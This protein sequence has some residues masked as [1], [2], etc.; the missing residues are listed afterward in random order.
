MLNLSRSHVASLGI[1]AWLLASALT[2]AQES[3]WQQR[4]NERLPPLGHRNWV[5]VADSAYP[6]QSREGIETI[7]TGEDQT[8]VLQYVFAA[9]NKSK[10]L[11]PV[12]YLDAELPFVAEQDA[13][14]ISA[15]RNSLTAL[16]KNQ[17]QHALPHEEIIEKLDSSAEMF[18]VLILKS[19]MRL[20]Y[21]SVFIELDCG[22]WS[23]EAEKRLRDA[24]DRAR[25]GTN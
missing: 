19:N 6:L 24:M 15:Y 25:V 14:G 12:I 16:L 22:Y 4:L 1:F 17:P 21:T 23:A 18:H 7:A 20:P 3:R 10:H 13:P 9:L 8:T 2:Q 11:R 5:V